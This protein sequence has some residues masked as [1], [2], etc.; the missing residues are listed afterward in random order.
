MSFVD[1]LFCS[2]TFT[3]VIL[4][5]KGAIVVI[6]VRGT[7]TVDVVMHTLIHLSFPFQTHNN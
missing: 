4:H 3:I 5:L 7:V 1:D 6:S 2:K